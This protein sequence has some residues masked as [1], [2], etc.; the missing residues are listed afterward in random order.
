MPVHE[1][2]DLLVEGNPVFAA[3]APRVQPTKVERFMASTLHAAE[4]CAR[5]GF[6]ITVETLRMMN[7][8]LSGPKVAELLGT[9]RFQHAAQA[10]GIPLTSLTGLSPQQ[11]LALRIYTDMSVPASHAQRLKLIGV[12]DATWRGW[13]RQPRF[14]AEVSFLAEA[15]LAAGKDVALLKLAEATSEGARWAVELTL[16]VTG[17][18]D[19]RREG[20]DVNQLLMAVFS[21][22]D[23]EVPDVAVLR[24]I[25][26]RIKQLMGAGAAPVLT[27]TQQPKALDELEQERPVI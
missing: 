19:R 8:E 10:R 13:L 22:L 25:D 2:D 18:H 11:L 26:D 14:A 27:I 3:R 9:E 24:R 5:Q 23:E 12:A 6:A 20:V 15:Q 16:E 4:Q 17:R 1:A 7:P 21:I